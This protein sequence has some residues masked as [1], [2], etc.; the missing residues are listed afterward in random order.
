MDYYSLLFAKKKFSEE[1]YEKGISKFRSMVDGSLTEVTAEDLEGVMKIK[2]Y[3]FTDCTKLLSVVIPDSVIEIEGR[4]F[5]HC[6]NLTS[7]ILP[8]SLRKI[9]FQTFAYCS[10]L[11]NLIIPVSVTE[12]ESNSF[13]M[14]NGLL[15]ITMKATT[16]PI[17]QLQSFNQTNNCPIYVPAESVQ[18]YKTA[19]NW[20]ALASRIFPI[21]EEGV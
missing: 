18:A 19:T 2:Q 21:P 16:P 1:G 12:I 11:A 3:N 6:T 4:A 10:A 9:I 14:C 13:Y 17:I 5:Q 8:N 7:V 15:S 20:S